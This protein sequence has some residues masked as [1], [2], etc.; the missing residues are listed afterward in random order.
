MKH[1]KPF[2]ILFLG[3]DSFSIGV[4]SNLL[5][6]TDVYN[7]ITVV[8]PAIKMTGRRKNVEY[9]P[10]L[11]KFA[12]SKNLPHFPVPPSGIKAFVPPDAFL[13]PSPT[14]LLITASFGSILP[15]SLLSIFEQDRKLNIH[16]SLLPKYR[17]ASPIQ[18]AIMNGDK[19]TGV[20][21]LG[22]SDKGTDRGDVWEQK[23]VPIPDTATYHSMV[24][25]LAEEGA[26]AL[27]KTLRKMI[28][29]S[30][31]STPQDPRLA[32]RAPKITH[33]HGILDFETQ[34]AVEIERLYRAIGH[35]Q[36]L[37]THLPAHTPNQLKRSP[38]QTL[39]LN[40]YSL[41]LPP[42]SYLPLHPPPPGTT[43][44]HPRLNALAVQCKEGQVLV[45]EG[46]VS[47]KHGGRVGAGE[48]WKGWRDGGR[49][50]E[51]GGVWDWVQL[52]GGGGGGGKGG[53]GGG[54]GGWE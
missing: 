38:P 39:P 10:E 22:M 52:G 44:Y 27:I 54:G 14:S 42:P 12:F 19:M 9:I 11:Q 49:V 17:G 4:L 29:R 32:S 3:S 33:D 6:S 8:T 40:L 24:P 30:A 46:Q 47:G 53:E 51:A 20:S 25:V 23:E 2:D 41:S 36:N 15:P 50:N 18:T 5:R 31:T 7:S 45:E 21:V 1:L 48:L 16:P 13:S 34:T 37:S 26:V 35:Q 28:N 43:F